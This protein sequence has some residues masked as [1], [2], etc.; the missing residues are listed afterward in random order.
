MKQQLSDLMDGEL[1]VAQGNA[2]WNALANDAELRDCWRTYH[3][4]G[5]CMRHEVVY[6]VVLHPAS[7][8]KIMGRLADEP[9]ILAP[10]RKSADGPISGKTRVALAMAASAATVAVIGLIASRQVQE[11]PVQ[12]AQQ[13]VTSTSQVSTQA[14]TQAGIPGVTPNV[15][16]YLILHRQF[17]N[18]EA[19]MPATLV[20]EGN[21]PR[22]AAGR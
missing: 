2:A 5:D 3:F 6:D 13:P 12:V 9:T 11:V 4:I 20:R 16:D 19:L 8:S 21:A 10:R 1:D 15:N 22:Q 17:A 7:T 14:N 18:P